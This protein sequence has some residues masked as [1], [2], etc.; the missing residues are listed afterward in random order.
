MS[1]F[2]GLDDL[3]DLDV[4]GIPLPRSEEEGETKEQWA[5][6]KTRESRE[7]AVKL[8]MEPRWQKAEAGKRVIQKLNHRH[9][10]MINYFLSGMQQNEVAELMGMSKVGVNII[11][12][13]PFFQLALREREK[14]LSD[15]L[16]KNLFN[17]VSEAK[18]CI[19][20]EALGAAQKLVELSQSKD[21]KIA[22]AA[23]K[24]L[25]DRCFGSTK[26]KDPSPGISLSGAQIQTLQV[27]LQESRKVG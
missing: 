20:E 25:L 1:K 18:K 19:E 12:N 4:G 8:D 11:Y 9:R 23:S 16:D 26:D 15:G 10:L 17:T 2:E 14:E 22:L 27:V 24:D 13:S 3:S 21:D 5:E 6:R 7:I